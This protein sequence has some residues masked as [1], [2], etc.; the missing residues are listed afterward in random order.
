MDPLISGDRHV[1]SA[2]VLDLLNLGLATPNYVS[3]SFPGRVSSYVLAGSPFV[4]GSSYYDPTMTTPTV[5]GGPYTLDQLVAMGVYVPIDATPLG[6]AMVSNG[7]TSRV[8]LNTTAFGT[9]SIQMQDRKNA[10]FNFQ[11]DLLEKHAQVFGSFFYAN[12]QSEGVLAPAPVP[13]LGPG[14]YNQIF[15][16][17]NNPYNP[18]GIDLGTPL[19]SGSPTV[20][21]RFVEVGNRTYDSDYNYYR[22]VA[23]L[24]GEIEKGYSYEIGYTYNRSEQIQYT[25]NSV[26]GQALNS[27]LVPDLA[28]DPTGKTSTL[29]D[30]AT[31]AEVPTYN[32]FGLPGSNDPR[33][34][35]A[36]RTTLFNS[37][38]TE[39]WG[40]DGVFRGKV[41]DLPAGE[42]SFAAGA[43][44]YHEDLLQ[45]ADALTATGNS[46][47]ANPI[48]P[49]PKRG[50]NTA[51]GFAEVFIPVF[52]PDKSVPGFHSLEISASGRYSSLDPGGD[53]A[54]PK[55]SVRWQPVDEHITLR[56]SYSQ[57]FIAQTLYTLFGPPISDAPNVSFPDGSSG[58]VSA[59]YPS[60]PS[61]PP[62]EA[63]TFTAGIVISPKCIPNLTV[64]VDWYK[65]NE[66]KV[67]AQPGVDLNTLVKS[68]NTLGTA[69]P[70]ASYVTLADGSHITAPGQLSTFDP[71]DLFIVPALPGAGQSTMGIDFSA[72]YVVPEDKTGFGKLTFAV[73]A[74][75][76]MNYFFNGPG[77]P[78]YDY[79][80]YYTVS[81]LGAEGTLPDFIIVPS[82][83]WEYK[84]LTA[85]VSARYIPS[86]NDIGDA[87]P[88][89]GNTENGTVTSGYLDAH[90][91]NWVIPAY[92][93]IDMQLA[94]EFGKNKMEGR[95]WYDGTTFRVGC[96]NITDNLAPFIAGSTEDNTDKSTY[97]IL[98]RFIYFEVSKKF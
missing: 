23:G 40:M 47:P 9:Y 54:V 10:F 70:Y 65:I 78:K 81:V 96:N 48:P 18:F 7:V 84:G 63:E 71:G 5:A 35:N 36:I 21:S 28:A 61:L 77:A 50:R 13:A 82:L 11:H 62:S 31:G 59:L 86:V 56:G 75:L 57:S 89:T 15:V 39:L 45:E 16:P 4:A 88:T 87:W 91:N 76:L 93:T 97:D 94:Y 1:A 79:A 2:G 29:V 6:S 73:N 80:G 69:S 49:F 58:Q 17:A 67:S 22:L 95:K 25:H 64:S 42:L 83:T 26:N 74:N 46:P 66:T 52:E 53:S 51:F 19:G 60:N 85:V 20:R 37:G 14:G 68:V 12:N 38:L 32:I 92:Y 55:V 72:N 90:G 33:T 44:Y 34:L 8:L 30:P 3:G 41:I 27:A 24:K 43:G 98:G